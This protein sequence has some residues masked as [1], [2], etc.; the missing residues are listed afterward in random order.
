MISQLIRDLNLTSRLA[1]QAQPLQKNECSPAQLLREC[2]ADIYNEGIDQNY[3]ID[4]FVPEEAE[5]IKV[6]ADEGLIR[7]ALRNLLGNSIRHNPHGCRISAS[8]CVREEGIS[9][10]IRDT[11]VGIPAVVI[12]NMKKQSSSIHIMGL[13]LTSQIAK[14]H[15]GELVFVKRESGTYDAEFWIPRL[16]NE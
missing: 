14:A 3:E 6:L 12:W 7:R 4:V 5:Q 1:Y 13:R 16:H 2:V 15:G 8:L 9:C 10:L 11:G